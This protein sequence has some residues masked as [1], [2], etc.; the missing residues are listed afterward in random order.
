LIDGSPEPSDDP[1]YVTYDGSKFISLFPDEES[2]GWKVYARIIQSDGTVQQG[3]YLISE[4]GWLLPFAIFGENKVLVTTTKVS[5]NSDSCFVLG[6]FFDLSLNPLGSE[7]TV[8]RQLSGKIPIGG[9]GAYVNGKF[10]AYTTRVNLGFTNQGKMYIVNGDIY[11]VSISYV[12][13]VESAEDVPRT[14]TLKQN[15]PNPFNPT[16]T[17]EF[18]IP[19]RVNVKLI[20]YDILAREISTLVDKELEPGKYKVDFDAKNLPSGVYFYRLEAGK[21]ASVKKMVLVR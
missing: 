19:E 16:T 2:T 1:V 9:V 21:F 10:Y 14:F 15:Y 3:R 6:R 18:E 8:F 4:N 11:G 20:V 17:I 12:T 5:Q 7:F 13:G